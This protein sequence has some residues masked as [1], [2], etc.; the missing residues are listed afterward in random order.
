MNRVAPIAVR[1]APSAARHIQDWKIPIRVGGRPVTI[2]GT[3]DYSPPAVTAA[4]G[5]S[6]AAAFLWPA[7]AGSALLLAGLTLV[8]V[9]R[10][11]GAAAL[12]DSSGEA[13][14]A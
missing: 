7:F 5:S 11:G 10:K 9:R 13:P 8:V 2:R 1:N 6:G 4:Q 12:G 14:S 3:L